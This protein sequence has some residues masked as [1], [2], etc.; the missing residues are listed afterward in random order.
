MINND[1]DPETIPFDGERDAIEALYNTEFVLAKRLYDEEVSRRTHL[2]QKF[3]VVMPIV[4]LF[5]GL[6]LFSGN[7]ILS[8]LLGTTYGQPWDFWLLVSGLLIYLFFLAS[9]ALAIFKTFEGMKAKTYTTPPTSEEFRA[10]HV[11][12]QGESEY[13]NKSKDQIERNLTHAYNV[14][15]KE[16]REVNESTAKYYN[17]CLKRLKLAFAC[18]LLLLLLIGFIQ[19]KRYDAAPIERLDKREVIR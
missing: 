4:G 16:N 15:G 18:A 1:P 9:V 19:I 8:V 17:C 7:T 11:K 6:G 12:R 13:I 2:F 14:A 3:N 5:A 10:F